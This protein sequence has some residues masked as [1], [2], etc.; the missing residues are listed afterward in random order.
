MHLLDSLNN[1]QSEV[2]S[3]PVGNQLVLAGAGSGKTRVLVHRIAWLIEVERISPFSILA[4][5]F[6][7]KA[8]AEM[9]HRIESLLNFP[10]RGMWVGT[11]HGLA[12]RLLRAHWQEAGL[13]ENFQI[14]DSDDQLRMIK[15]VLKS[16]ELSEEKWS[17]K[18][19]QGFINWQKDQGVRPDLKSEGDMFQ[20]TMMRIYHTYE[21]ACHRAGAVDFAE[22]LLRSFELWR[23]NPEL[24]AHYQE[25]F[26]E[27]LVDEFQDTNTLQ[28]AWLKLLAQ[29]RAHV[30]VVGDDDQSIYGWRG[31]EIDNIHQFSKDFPGTKTIRLEQNYRSTGNILAAANALIT[32]NGNRLGKNLWTQDGKGEPISLYAAFNEI[33][34]ARF[35]SGQISQWLEQGNR[36]SEVAILYR[37]NAQSRVLEEALIQAGIPYRVYGGLRFFDRAEIK[38]A[39]AYLRLI[40]HRGNDA[41]FERVINTP[42]RGIG[43]RTVALLREEAKQQNVT[44]WQAAQNLLAEQQLSGRAAVAVQGFCELIDQLD[45]TASS[46]ELSEQTD[47]VIQKSGLWEFYAKSKTEQAQSRLENLQELIVATKQFSSSLDSETP[48]LAEFLSH[49]ALES[50]ENQGEAHQDCVQLMTLHTA[51]G[52]EFPLVFIC[53]V[54]EGLFPHKMSLQEK[55]GVEEE[56][57]LLYVGMTRAMR[58]L[59]ITYAELRRQYGSEEY[60]QPSRFIKEIPEELLEEVRM[61]A[62]F[63]KP[64]KPEYDM[65]FSQQPSENGFC[66]GQPVKHPE[67]G[68]GVVMSFEGRGVH[69]RIQIKF[70]KHGVKWLVLSYANLKPIEEDWI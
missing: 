15:R 48:A 31:A 52:L 14:L 43:E 24:L 1:E 56:R 21:E 51:K 47:L 69:A 32:N 58:K 3:S 27:I 28:Y 45:Q 25:R 66:L 23:K 53:G 5:T 64:S 59:T 11:F 68:E 29:P 16:L 42:Q 50:G 62:T 35:V 20:K 9:R 63:S 34:E 70:K 13:I 44:L 22:L 65:G 12:N 36:R 33:D 61:K 67:F 38:D 7:N 39:L 41:A 55:S 37:S 26:S 30:M 60:H 46:L 6:T 4:V 18:Q 57:R 2:V 17:P 19:V 49:A 8:A 54:E 10:I 40:H